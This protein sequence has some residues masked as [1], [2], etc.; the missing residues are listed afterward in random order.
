MA[1]IALPAATIARP[2]LLLHVPHS[3]LFH[4]IIMTDR[5]IYLHVCTIVQKAI[6]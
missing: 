1:G 4:I 2:I 3:P 6:L 5:V